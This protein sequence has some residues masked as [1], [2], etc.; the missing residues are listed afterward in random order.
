[1]I[2]EKKG[3]PI[4]QKKAVSELLQAET[5][6]CIVVIRIISNFPLLILD[7]YSGLQDIEQFTLHLS[8]FVVTVEILN[9][10]NWLEY[11]EWLTS[12]SWHA[13]IAQF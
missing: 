10:W 2:G 1:M 13:K 3:V 4:K 7:V 9:P 8:L 6:T 12:I 11:T 5:W